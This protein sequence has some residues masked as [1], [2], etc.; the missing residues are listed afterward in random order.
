MLGAM[1]FSGA[2]ADTFEYKFKSTP[3][4]VALSTLSEEH[5]Q[6]E[7]NFIYDELENYNISASVSTDDP[8][9]AL[10]TIV[11][12]NP[13]TISKKNDR[14]FLEALQRGKYRYTGVLEGNDREPVTAATVMILSPKDSTV[15]TYGMTDESGHFSIPCDKKGVIGKFSCIGY[16]PTYHDFTSF[17][18]GRVKMLESPVVLRTVSVEAQRAS[19]H[20]DRTVYLPSMRQKNTSQNAIDLL[21]Q[22]AIPQIDIN[23]IDNTVTDNA[24]EPVEIY[25]NNLEASQEELSGLRMADVRRIE[26]LE[27]PSDPRFRGATRVI[28]IIMQAY[29]YGGYTKITAEENV[30]IGLAS[31]AGVFSKFSYKKMVYD[32][33]AGAT[34]TDNRHSASMTESIYRLTDD[35]GASRAVKRTETPDAS[36]LKENEYPV[37]FRAT[38]STQKLQLRNMVGYS[39]K[40]NPVDRQWGSVDFSE[41]ANTHSSYHRDNSNRANSFSYSGTLFMVLP[42]S[43]SLNVSPTIRYTHRNDAMAYSVADYRPIVRNARE[44]ALLDGITAL[45]SKQFRKKHTV[46]ISFTRSEFINNLKYAQLDNEDKYHMEM[47][48][49]KVAYSYMS[50]KV[51]VNIDFGM[52][53]ERSSLNG[54]KSHATHPSTNINVQ[55]VPDTKNTWSLSLIYSSSLSPVAQKVSDVLQDN[56][57]MYLT[58]NPDLKSNRL[59]FINPSYTWL[60]SNKFT[61][62]AFATYFQAFERPIETYVAY[63]DGTALLRTYKNDGNYSSCTVGTALNWKLMDGRLQLSSKP[64]LSMYNSTGIYDKAITAFSTDVQAMYYAGKMYFMAYYRTPRKSMTNETPVMTRDRAYYNISVGWSDNNWN[65]KASAI[66]MF[67]RGYRASTAIT[68][69]LLYTNT[70]IL[71]GTMYHPCINISATYTIGYGKKVQRNNEVG[72]QSGAS[73]AILK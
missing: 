1:V 12:F 34:N 13:I 23:P 2:I 45:V 62:S 9:D 48:T 38:Y 20:P 26:Y 35:E 69:S 36:R 40:G 70:R 72:G 8:Y 3:I 27:S 14:Y 44:D 25:I 59:I 43:F 28:N 60:I 24:G 19:S 68:E 22:M 64:R 29:A 11:G 53:L 57:F 5:P 47:S 21:R 33:Y 30:L 58:G 61:F 37:T 15:I 6:I 65:I 55:Y 7:I 52:D 39:F 71:Y 63:K 4:A 42:K 46:M 32:L 16:L 31:K 56:E 18:V 73:S 17:N 49:G 41:G 54:E 50:P 67:N 51:G 66:N 10:R